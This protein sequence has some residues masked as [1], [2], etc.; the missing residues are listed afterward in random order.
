MHSGLE[1]LAQHFKIDQL[2]EKKKE[3]NDGSQK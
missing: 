1:F 2:T 3:K